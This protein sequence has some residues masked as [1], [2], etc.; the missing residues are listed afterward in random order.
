M[1]LFIIIIDI[2]KLNLLTNIE[3]AMMILDILNFFMI[4]LKIHMKVKLQSM[5]YFVV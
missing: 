2:Q 1:E 3:I 5:K 4:S